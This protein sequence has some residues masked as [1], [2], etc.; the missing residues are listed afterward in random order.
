VE[1]GDVPLAK[2]ICT[3]GKACAHTLLWTEIGWVGG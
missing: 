2:V 3:K 1:Q